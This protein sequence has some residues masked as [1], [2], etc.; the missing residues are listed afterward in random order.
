ME[1]FLAFI[2]EYQK[3][4]GNIDADWRKILEL[5]FLSKLDWLEYSLKRLLQIECTDENEQEMGTIEVVGTIN[6]LKQYEEMVSELETWL[7]T[8][9]AIA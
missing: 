2:D 3:G 7:N 8:L 5:G 6:T 4:I 1:K 9:D